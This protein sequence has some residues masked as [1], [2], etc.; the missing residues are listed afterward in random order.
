MEN[1]ETAL[2][3]EVAAQAEMVKQ[4][5]SGLGVVPD[6]ADGNTET[7]APSQTAVEMPQQQDQA[8]S[9]QQQMSDPA[10]QQSFEQ[11][12]GNVQDQ[13]GDAYKAL[14]AELERSKAAYQ[15]L[16]GKYSAE[17]PRLAQQVRELEAEIAQQRHLQTSRPATESRDGESGQFMS[18][19]IADLGE[20][21]D[22]ALLSGDLDRVKEIR[23]QMESVRREEFRRELE[24]VRQTIQQGRDERYLSDLNS[25]AS[26]WNEM[27]NDPAFSEFL[28]RPAPFSGEPLYQILNQADDA[29]NAVRVAEV[30]NAFR[31][32]QQSQPTPTQREIPGS[33]IAPP[34]SGNM[35]APA[36]MPTIT[37]DQLEAAA[38]N[39]GKGVISYQQYEAMQQQYIKSMFGST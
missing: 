31:E 28:Q 19:S 25:L 23:N 37:K 24:P 6:F 32:S 11:A 2:P 36:K 18:G 35:S 39:V 5:M 12:A 8:T 20:Q 15:V 22:E 4:Y 14:Q 3:A 34:R 27:R 9:V 21:M 10:D 13:A 33:L 30:Y 16:Q 17:V 38:A 29:R 26:G 7:T 1:F